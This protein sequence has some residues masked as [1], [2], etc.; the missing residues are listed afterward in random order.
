MLALWLCLFATLNLRAGSNPIVT[1]NA[2]SGPGSLRDVIE[3]ATDGA[4][5]Q[6]APGI[7]GQT[8]TLTTAEL[9]INASITIVGPGASQLTVQRSTENGTPSFRIFEITPGHTV[10]IQGLTIRNG[11][12]E[13]AAPLN[14]GGGIYND[15]STLTVVD[16][17]ISENAAGLSG[18]S[19]RG[20][21]IFS[22]ASNLTSAALVI[23]GTTITGNSAGDSGGGIYNNGT[24]ASNSASVFMTEATISANS[25]T[26]GAGV[27][28]DGHDSGSANLVV[29]NSTIS[30]NA[31]QSQ[32]GGVLNLGNMQADNTRVTVTNSTISG[33]SS[34]IGG[35][36]LN[37]GTAGAATLE[38]LHCTISNNSAAQHGGAVYNT[39]NGASRPK[40]KGRPA[41]GGPSALVSLKNTILDRGSAGENIYN[42]GGEVT[43]NGYNLSSDDGSGF[44]TAT[45]DQIQANPFLGPLEDNG[46]PTL[47]HALRLGSTAID[48]GDPD[49]VSPPD[50]DQRGVGFPRLFGSRIDIGSF[51]LQEAAETQLLNISTR[52]RVL[53]GDNAL[54]GGF[55]VSGSVPK[56]VLI[57]G[58]GPSLG[59]FGVPDPLTDPVLELHGPAGF[60]TVVN[61]NWRDT[62]E[63]EIEATGLAPTN[64]LESAIVATLPAGAYTAV[65]RGSNDGV[66]VG[67]VEIYEL[68]F[69]AVSKLDNISTRGF[70]EAGD[71]AMI[72]GFI[73]AIGNDPAR[74][75]VRGI[76]PSLGSFGVPDALADPTLELHNS[77]GAIVA[78]NDNWRDTQEAE[79]QATG[80]PPSDDHEAAIVQTL[81]PAAYT[82]ILRGKNDTTGVALVE[83]YR[84]ASPP[85][86]TPTP[87]PTETPTP[88]PTETPTP[89][90]TETPTPTSTPSPTPGIGQIG[91]FSVQAVAGNNDDV[92][93]NAFV[94]T[95][96]NPRQVIVRGL[97]PGICGGTN[98]TDPTLELRTA[99]GALLASNNNWRD[100][101][102]AEIIATGFAPTDDVEAA[103]LATLNPGVYTVVLHDNG[104]ATGLAVNDLHDLSPLGGTRISAIGSR[105]NVVSGTENL[106]GGIVL[107]E[108]SDVLVRALGLSLATAG[109]SSPLGDPMLELRDNNGTLIRSNDDWQDDPDQAA[110]IM[111]TG[112]APSDLLESAMVVHLDPGTYT[113][114]VSGPKG[115]TGISYLQ[116][117][118]LPNIGS[119]LPL[120]P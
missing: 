74:V 64:D 120:T 28:N 52:L 118:T 47:T 98:I 95:G 51:E 44:L 72:G 67:L 70:V 60:V 53:A 13:G 68:E 88:T 59:N 69:A 117:Y 99:G 2:D 109:I 73:L 63:S 104:D 119:P 46:G 100:T 92:V 80:A 101:Q 71:N 82:A 19:G 84:L 38:I 97:C 76:G 57:R 116:F 93:M 14:W 4:I 89:T 27:V 5:I 24:G 33:N 18:S 103:I 91:S 15:G 61:N 79:I 62:Q 66:G 42:D 11:L 56:R 114:T 8:I 110:L 10:T 26:N 21:G 17:I 45:G 22:N 30:G 9:L 94:I 58:L 1:T 75:L 43:S 49:F 65:V 102:E 32:G 83:A 39:S 54:I 36:F 41:G 29:T 34:Q 31:A 6:F 37:D 40:I 112:L 55:I 108:G 87:T 20:A 85:T 78:M 90:P 48:A 115:T 77:E 111:A 23:S 25:A 50:F 107:Q 96:T 3:A 105:G 7:N 16:S 106:T 35:A 113:G 81:A 12:A 86:P